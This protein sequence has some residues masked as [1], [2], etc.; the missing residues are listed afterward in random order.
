MT[1]RERVRK[2]LNFEQADRPAI[3]LG[4][5][6]MTGTSA[7]TYQAL[8]NAL[9]IKGGATRVFDLFQM[10]AEVEESVLDA[11]GCDFVMVPDEALHYGL[12]RNGWIDYTFWDGQTFQVPTGFRP[13]ELESLDLLVGD[14]SDW[15]E[16]VAR[17]PSGGRYFDAINV[18]NLTDTFEVPHQDEADW[19]LPG[20][21]DDA[22]LEKKLAQIESL[23]ESTDRALVT[24]PPF[25]LSSGYGGLYQ[26][27]MKMALE[28]DHCRAYMVAQGEASA[29][30]ARQ[31][32]GAVGEYVDVVVL[33]GADYGTQDREAY[34]PS[35]FGECMTPGWKIVCDAVHEFPNVKVWVHS[36]GSIPGMIPHMVEAGVDC[37]NPVQWGA[38]GMDR[39][40]M[41]D[42][43]GDRLTFWGGT[44]NTQNTFP[45]GTP[46]EVRAE[47]QECL[48]IFAPGGGHVVNPIHN[49]QADVPV[50]NILALYE[51]ARN[52]RY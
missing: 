48:D 43:F 42:T 8:K 9:S 28:P 1:S 37:L 36:C 50:E 44:I 40:W 22:L 30:R 47:A 23:Y 52:Y 25:N 3:D 32:L 21:I 39:K 33:T 14:G 26:W 17:M 7:W 10:L 34:R 46:D 49:I 41:K 12:T 38:A 18:A 5:T 6:R 45:F 51:T 19:N 15:T 31:F 24:T 2:I 29:C 4:A 13:Q 11:L 20:P 16:P 35:L 27:G